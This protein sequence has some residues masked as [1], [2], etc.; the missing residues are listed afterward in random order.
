MMTTNNRCWAI[1]IGVA[2]AAWLGCG[3]DD[4]TAPESSS[5]GSPATGTAGAGDR[6]EPRDAAVD[7]VEAPDAADEDPAPQL[8]D[9]A[10]PADPG[11]DGAE[12]TLLMDESWTLPAGGEVAQWCADMVVNED[13]YISAVRPIH[14]AGTHHTTLSITE[15]Q[16]PCSSAAVFQNGIIYAAGVGTREL[17]MPEGVAL[18]LPA[19]YVLHLGLHIYNVSDEELAGVSGIEVVRV[20]PEDVEHEAELLIAGPISL[21]IPPGRHT[22]TGTCNVVED[23]TAF[24]LFPHMHQLGV[25]LKTTVT[26]GGEDVILH[27]G[28][29]D[30]EEQ[31]QVPID[32]L[33]LHMGD[34]ITTD[35]TFDNTTDRT[36]TFGESS[37]TEMCFSVFFRYPATGNTFCRR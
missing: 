18:K 20:D 35:C 30:F 21:E 24:A 37:D 27:D 15:E 26:V 14:P 16:T 29:Y 19:G 36:V 22:I 25:H 7:P 12:W 9:A 32:P 34:T 28:E 13:M 5:A 8:P 11:D 4:A 6:P 1:Y 33:E 3:D 17:R 31:Y 2:A 23:Q 10:Q